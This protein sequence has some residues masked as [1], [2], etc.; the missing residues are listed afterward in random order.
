MIL[1]TGLPGSGK[2]T[3]ATHLASLLQKRGEVVRVVDNHYVYNVILN[4]L[5]V[6]VTSHEHATWAAIESVREAIF[7]TVESL[8]PPSW[9]FVFTEHLKLGDEWFVER[10][11]SI[12]RTRRSSFVPVRLVCELSELE[13]RVV[14]GERAP[15]FKSVSVVE[16]W[17]LFASSKALEIIHDN[18]LTL[19]NTRL[20]AERTARRILDHLDEREGGRP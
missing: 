18:S 6:D 15:R 16:T 11:Q 2:L 3:V 12:A 5:P 20:S 9:S 10:V 19:N 4:L 13:R 14:S 17:R 8:S 1:L 7:R